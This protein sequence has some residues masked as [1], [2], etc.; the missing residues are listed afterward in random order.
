MQTL[1][2]ATLI[3]SREILRGSSWFFTTLE[4]T[5]NTKNGYKYLLNVRKENSK[6]YSQKRELNK[7][8]IKNV[9]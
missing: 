8:Q 1:S 4:L 3:K 7:F 2:K 5:E 9:K 6:E